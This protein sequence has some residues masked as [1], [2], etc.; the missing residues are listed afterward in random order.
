MSEIQP[1]SDREARA[2]DLL[3]C[4]HR[5]RWEDATEAERQRELDGARREGYSDQVSDGSSDSTN[6]VAYVG[7]AMRGRLDD[8]SA[9]VAIAA[10]EKV[11]TDGAELL[12]LDSDRLRESA[13]EA[14]AEY[15]LIVESTRLFEIVLGTGGPD[16]RLILE[17][18]HDGMGTHLSD[19]YEIRRVLYRYSWSGSAEVELTGE[20]REIAEAFARRVVPELVE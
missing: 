7:T 2:R 1:I 19:G 9:L 12:G 14:L 10:E 6:A 3:L 18:D 11:S 17:C 4:N 20:D 5:K 15:P 16:D 13:E 8:L